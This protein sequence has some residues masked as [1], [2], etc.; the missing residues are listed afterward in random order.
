MCMWHHENGIFIYVFSKC[1]LLPRSPGS[2]Q[3]VSHY[4]VIQMDSSAN[5]INSSK[6]SLPP[7]YSFG[8]SGKQSIS[9]KQPL[10]KSSLQLRAVLTSKTRDISTSS[11]SDDGKI[12]VLLLNLGGPE[13]LEDVQPFLFNLFAD[14]VLSLCY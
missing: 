8:W 14:P 10:T 1:R 12:G 4:S 5:S 11:V 6:T 7:R 3:M 13:T 2:S 9:L